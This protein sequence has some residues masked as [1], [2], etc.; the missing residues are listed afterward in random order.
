[1]S[2]QSASRL[3]ELQAWVDKRFPLTSTWRYHMTEYYVPK[4]INFWYLF[5]SLSILV[6]VIQII[7]GIWLTM[8]YQPSV[9]RAF[10]S[11]EFIMRDVEWGWLMRYLHTVG[12]SAFFV[13]VYLHMF[14]CLMYGSYKKPRELL[15]II[16]VLI[17][18]VMMTEAFMGYALPWGQLSY[19]AT[20]V[21]V[22]LFGVVPFIGD[23]LVVWLQGGFLVNEA[24]LGRLFS[25]HVI[26]LPLVLILL[27]FLHIVAL[28][29]VGS[30]S[31][32]GVEIKENKDKNGKPV[33]GIAFHPYV[34]VKDMVG[35]G[36]FLIIFCAIVFFAPEFFGYFIE[37]PNLEEANPLQTPETIHPIWYFTAWYAMLQCVPNEALGVV[38][39]F[40]GSMILLF[41]PWIDRSEVRSIRYR[42]RGFKI[43]L[44]VFVASFLILTWAGMQ[45]PSGLPMLI[46][47]IFTVVYFGFFVFLWVYTYFGFEQTKPVP[48]RVTDK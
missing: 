37:A 47:R 8:Y 18:L 4:N 21:I 12:A 32:D 23:D 29:H 26:G 36:I 40:A 3:S 44:A 41:L 38:V 24:T 16:G 39:M 17:Y 20:Q 30:S 14:R 15:W 43:A 48:E 9:D 6:L 33:D 1:M 31:P 13:V 5:G 19:W 25:L 45:E 11:V 22:A 34:T 2:E 10:A 27:V 35:M 42:G 28:H 7:T 46:S